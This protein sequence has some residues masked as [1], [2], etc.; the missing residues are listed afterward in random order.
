MNVAPTHSDAPAG[1]NLFLLGA[2]K[3]GT[4]NLYTSLSRHPQIFFSQVKE[5]QFFVHDELYARGLNHYLNG[6][7]AAGTAWPIRGDATPH[8]LYYEKAAQRIAQNLHG[9][10]LRFVVSVRNPVARAYSLYWN[11]VAEGIETL[12]FEAAL[13]QEGDRISD[14]ELAQQGAVSIHYVSS[15][16]YA[17]QIRTYLRYFEPE[18]FHVVVFEEL[19]ADPLRELNAVCD[20]LQVDRFE[21]V[22]QG[23]RTNAAT[24]PR[25]T[26]VHHFLRGSSTF[27]RLAGRALPESVKQRAVSAVLRLNSRTHKYP[28]MNPETRSRLKKAFAEDI[29]DL[30]TLLQRPLQCWGDG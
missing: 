18:Q 12:S 20:F 10:D 27:K 5:P 19:L 17:R 15:S 4:T 2:A 23:G 1:P 30:E 11:M 9:P 29:A 14:P 16:L 7:F 25:S 8:Y 3:A 26:G 28:P 13:A 21:S 22:P 6:H 24:M